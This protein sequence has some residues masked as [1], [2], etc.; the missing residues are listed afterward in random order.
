MPRAYT[1]AE[2]DAAFW[3]R[4]GRDDATGCWPWRGHANAKGYGRLQF[5]G[6]LELAHRVAFFMHH[7]R[8]PDPCA[9]HRCDNPPCCN[10]SHMFEGDQALN[11]EDKRAKRRHVFGE[12]V[13]TRKLTEDDVR[14]IRTVGGSNRA[15][16]A[17]FGVDRSTISTIRSGRTWS[18]VT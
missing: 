14:A 3:A 15:L 2:Q 8:W 1:E 6:R 7:G 16:A 11:N 10:V 17:R 5:R 18:H 12:A 13:H 9:L 4:V